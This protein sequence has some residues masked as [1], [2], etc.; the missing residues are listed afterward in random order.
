MKICILAPENSPSW[1]GVGCYVYNLAKNLPKEF[2]VHIITINR[3]VF[4]SYD[5]LLKNDNINIY[6]ITD[7]S[8]NNSFFYNY[9]FQMSLLR[10]LKGFQKNMKFDIIHS[11]S[12]HLPHIFTQF[13]NIAPLIVTVHATVRGMKRGLKE[14]K[15]AES[16]TEKLMDMFSSFI[17][18]GEKISFK[19]SEKLLPVSEFTLNEIE[20]IYKVNVK[21]KSII[22]KNATDTDMFRPRYTEY[23]KEK[24]ITFIGRFYA[25]K[26]FDI[27]LKS[28]LNINKNGYK[29]KPYLIGRGDRRNLN[30]LL[31]NNFSNFILQDLTPYSEIPKIFNYSDIV[32]IP[33]RY[34]NCPAV[35]LEAMSSGKIVIASNAGGIP[36]I[37]ENEKNGFLFENGNAVEL[38]KKIT[39]VLDETYNLK[40]IRNNARNTIIN[41]YQWKNRA[42]EIG[43]L[44]KSL[45]NQ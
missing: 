39:S 37:I 26:G 24:V 34:D 10:K 14:Y 28:I 42:E 18:I 22:V 41:N 4:D 21:N 45:N 19:K 25:I 32:V 3:D 27:Y 35:V 40:D 23:N 33:S 29:I 43:K 13:Q 6:K 7:V 12:G 15:F 16:Q 44:Y 20:N 9:S 38:Q 11:H 17:E 2:D 36:E 8:K 30:R 31:K 1:G 5:K